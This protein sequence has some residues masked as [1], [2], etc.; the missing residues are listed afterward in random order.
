MKDHAKDLVEFHAT[1]LNTKTNQVMTTLTIL[2][3]IF[4]P[5]T[6]IAGVYGMNFEVMPELSWANGY[7]YALTF[8]G[9]VG[10]IMFIWMKTRR[11]F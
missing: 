5:L 11:W 7:Y 2:S 3:S 4:I 9:A 10:L 6:F 1:L 8:M